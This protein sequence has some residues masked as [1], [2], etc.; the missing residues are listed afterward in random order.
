MNRLSTS[1]MLCVALSV[2]AYQIDLPE[3]AIPAEKT[4]KSELEAGLKKMGLPADALPP[5]HLGQTE[6]AAAVFGVSWDALKPDQILLKWLERV[7]PGDGFWILG[8]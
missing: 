6:R 4:A 2:W 7:E 5:F 8:I 1:L 3:D